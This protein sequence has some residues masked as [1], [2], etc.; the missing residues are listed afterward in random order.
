MQSLGV[1][2]PLFFSGCPLKIIGSMPQTCFLPGSLSNWEWAQT[3]SSCL[4]L[5]RNCM[6]RTSRDTWCFFK[7]AHLGDPGQCAISQGGPNLAGSQHRMR[8]GMTPI[9]HPLWF[10]LRESQTVHCQHPGSFPSCRTGKC[11]PS[12]GT[13]TPGAHNL[14]KARIQSRSSARGGPGGGGGG[15]DQ[16]EDGNP[17]GVQKRAD[18][19]HILN[20][21]IPKE[22]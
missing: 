22:I 21:G 12:L 1:C 18:K 15:C 17:R 13:Q 14:P 2:L 19:H 5:P 8:N 9:N 11:P 10:P 3:E 20:Q 7:F 4:W 16:A 6:K